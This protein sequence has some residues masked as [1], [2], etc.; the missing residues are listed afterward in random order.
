MRE[1][2]NFFLL[3]V[4]ALYIYLF[5][6]VY[7]HIDKSALECFV[8]FRLAWYY[9]GCIE[10]LFLYI[11]LFVAFASTF[12]LVYFHSSS[13]YGVNLSVLKL[14]ISWNWNLLFVASPFNFLFLFHK[15][16]LVFRKDIL[17]AIRCQRDI[18]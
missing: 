6:H 13:L 17:L 12:I 15:E 10:K 7:V 2:E 3:I 9:C 1:E 8:Q 4:A 5:K 14:A 11:L 18:G 16:K